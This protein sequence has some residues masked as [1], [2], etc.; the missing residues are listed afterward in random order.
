MDQAGRGDSGVDP[1]SSTTWRLDSLER[2]AG[3]PVSVRGKPSVDPD[4]IRFDGIGDQILIGGHPLPGA[5]AFTVEALILPEAGVNQANDPRFF[6][7]MDPADTSERRL[8]MEIRVN[9]EGRWSFDAMLRTDA[10]EKALLD[11][12]LQH[13]TRQWAA[14]AVVY[15]GAVLKAFVNGSLELQAPLSFHR[16]IFGPGAVVSVGSRMNQVHF[17]A[18]TIRMLRFTPAALA[19]HELLRAG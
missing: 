1:L 13:P 9:T 10:G 7:L 5:T 16:E 2:I 15:D 3:H 17:F 12:A 6:H 18:G 8:M 14:A 4:G 19:P 11:P